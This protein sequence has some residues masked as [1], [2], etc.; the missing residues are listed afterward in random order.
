M[1]PT[2][3]KGYDSANYVVIICARADLFDFKHAWNTENSY[4]E[5]ILKDKDDRVAY[6]RAVA[7]WHYIIAIGTEANNAGVALRLSTVRFDIHVVLQ[8]KLLGKKMYLYTER[9]QSCI[10]VV[11]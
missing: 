11:A 5:S 9:T 1:A 8:I 10:V 2:A 3:I 6:A 4:S 7:T